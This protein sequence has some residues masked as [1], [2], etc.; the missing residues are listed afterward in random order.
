MTAGPAAILAVILAV[1][2][3]LAAPV[4]AADKPAAGGI[5]L[6]LSGS[7]TPD[8]IKRTVDGLA[9][10]G[11]RVTLRIGSAGAEAAT[12]T[13]GSD[14]TTSGL[15]ALW[16]DF[17][18]GVLRGFEGLPA[19]P[20]LAADWERNW[21]AVT[22]A[23]SP[24]EGLAKA[25]ATI[26]IALLAALAL[27]WLTNR[28]W[29]IAPGPVG[30]G[31]AFLPRLANAAARMAKDG[32]ALAVFVLA[33]W[34][35]AVMLLPAFDLL[36][37]TVAIV[38]HHMAIAAI[39]LIAARFLLLPVATGP[40][41][42]PIDHA[43]RHR[44]TVIIY[45]VLAAVL[46]SSVKVAASIASD[47]LSVI[48]WLSL[49]SA[50]VTLYKLWWFWTARHDVARLVRDGAPDPG[51]P[52]A[53][54][55]AG[56]VAMPWLLL[57]SVIAIWVITR[58]AVVVP[59][60]ERWVGAAGLTQFIIILVPIL[61][62][63][64]QKVAREQLLR[65][66]GADTVRHPLWAAILHVAERGASWSIWIAGIIAT[67]AAWDLIA[68]DG[69]VSPAVAALNRIALTAAI[70]FAG[71]IV[72]TFLKSLLDQH[73]PPAHVAALPSAEDNAEATVQSRLAS[74][75]P[76]LRGFLL[77]AV[78]ALTALVALSKLG[79]DT[80]PLL[81]GFGILGLAISFGSQALV[82]DVVSGVFFMTEDA[83][84]VGEYIDTG[85]LK[86]TVEKIA[87]RSVQLRHQSGLVHTIPFGQIA[88]VTNASRDWATVKFNIRID[89]RADLEKVRKTIKKVGQSLQEDP[90]FGSE[91]ILPLKMQG[92]SDIVDN[93]IVC[94]LK[95]TAKPARS[96]WVQREALKRVY[97]GLREA[98]IDFA[99]NA[100]MV[101]SS[102]GIPMS[103]AGAGAMTG[104]MQQ[105][106]N[107]VLP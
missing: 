20:R 88:S 30:G 83:F 78:I 14:D 104:R 43:S 7:E 60:G 92:V 9:K 3:G 96:G 57:A 89:R 59:G 40:A 87:L 70:L 5:T 21:A 36:R 10:S 105:A 6:E 2:S 58:I 51:A 81:A 73:A 12:A 52:S 55:R 15:A 63:G 102:D 50:V 85:K 68:T 48:G 1:L 77:G 107:G 32:M 86:G 45:G 82:R 54:R 34:A 19:I 25:L 76:V 79:I 4:A 27:R 100:V 8:A 106:N 17:A 26:G 69:E 24:A 67:A 18:Q 65:E 31:A 71:F 101:Q 56:A 61:A 103:A 93:A 84:R 33:A 41:L 94:R 64:A 74:V 28:I 98:D 90:E 53:A 66:V 97:K 23:T 37:K 95:F 38:V 35:L 46:I 16:D 39:Y 44:R 72:L 22:N 42:M 13:A 29:P 91:I 80:G 47:K 49:T 62:A 11:Q 75:L 99:Y